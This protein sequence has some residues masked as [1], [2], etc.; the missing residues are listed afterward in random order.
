VITES[1]SQTARSGVFQRWIMREGKRK[2]GGTESINR[3]TIR[4]EVKDKA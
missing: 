4:N 1:E 3:L 2:E